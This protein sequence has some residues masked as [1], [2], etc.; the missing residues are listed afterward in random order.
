LDNNFLGLY[1]GKALLRS[2]ILQDKTKVAEFHKCV[3]CEDELVLSQVEQNLT[4][5]YVLNLTAKPLPDGTPHPHIQIAQ[6]LAEG[7]QSSQGNSWRNE[8]LNAVPFSFPWSCKHFVNTEDPKL[9]GKWPIP[10]PGKKD[11]GDFRLTLELDYVHNEFPADSAES[12]EMF[13]F[14]HVIQIL[15]SIPSDTSRIQFVRMLSLACFFRC[16][17][18]ER[19]IELF[20]YRE[21]R[22]NVAIY[23]Y[24]RVVDHG[25]YMDML[26]STLG[27]DHMQDV[28]RRLGPARVFNE[29]EPDGHYRL[30]LNKKEDRDLLVHLLELAAGESEPDVDKC[31]FMIKLN[32]CSKRPIIDAATQEVTWGDIFEEKVEDPEEKVVPEALNP[33]APPPPPQIKSDG[34]DELPFK[35]PEM[36]VL[37]FD[38]VGA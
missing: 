23:F 22:V 21:E 5:H 9:N 38:Y 36:G 11:K 10:A 24:N 3:L 14:D 34:E 33:D 29:E 8:M 35:I 20:P 2:I 26:I 7:A 12:V 30:I 16:G 17:Q 25:E 19:I 15:Q 13:I 31:C 27:I 6:R 1:A 4:G 37:E 28:A 32:A 18:V